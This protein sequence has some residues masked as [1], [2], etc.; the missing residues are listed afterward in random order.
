MSLAGTVVFIWLD[1]HIISCFEKENLKNRP[2][3]LH[4][5]P[6]KNC[7]GNF[8]AQQLRVQLNHGSVHLGDG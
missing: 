5:A 4:S 3:W 8:R 1:E 7:P 2:E 6:M